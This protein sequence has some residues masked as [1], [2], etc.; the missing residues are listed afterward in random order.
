[1]L[2]SHV[3]SSGSTILMCSSSSQCC[4]VAAW[5]PAI[6]S[7]F[8]PQEGKEKGSTGSLR[9]GPGND[10]CCFCPARGSLA[11]QSRDHTWLPERQEWTLGHAGDRPRPLAPESPGVAHRGTA[12]ELSRWALPWAGCAA[13]GRGEW[14]RRPESPSLT[15]LPPS[16]LH[17]E[18]SNLTPA[19]HFQDFRFKT[20]APVAFRYFRELFGIRP[21][22]YLVRAMVGRLVLRVKLPET[23]VSASSWFLWVGNSGATRPASLPSVVVEGGLGPESQGDQPGGRSAS[24]PMSLVGPCSLP[25]GLF[26]GAR[27]RGLSCH[28][29]HITGPASMRGEVGRGD[30]LSASPPVLVE[31]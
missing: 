22:D 15:G 25:G 19:H 11:E 31:S 13:G 7:A 5:D 14:E 6:T 18:G 16:L 21:D 23:R 10:V 4:Q 8:H 17:S 26:L 12:W 29:C 1:M 3:P 27:T 9:A 2:G 28:L 20:Y 24:E 30:Q